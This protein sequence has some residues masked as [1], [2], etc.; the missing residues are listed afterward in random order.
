MISTP[1]LRFLGI[2]QTSMLHLNGNIL[3]SVAALA[4]GDDP[5][6]DEVYE[7]AAIPVDGFIRKSTDIRWFHCI[8]R[9]DAFDKSHLAN[10]NAC[11]KKS[12]IRQAIDYGLPE[13]KARDLF[14][15]WYQKLELAWNKRIAPLG[16]NYPETARNLHSWFGPSTYAGY[17]DESETRDISS[18]ARMVLDL[19][20]F[21]VTQYSYPNPTLGRLASR[22]KIDRDYWDGGALAIAAT[23]ADCYRE[24]L[25]DIVGMMRFV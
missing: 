23:V 13:M 19:D 20:S 3:C 21:R 25:N 1:I 9:P 12:Q 18:L 24:M 16:F 2:M 7:F 14:H 10:M 5:T 11:R 22:L 15:N 4:V 8:I 6:I 17:F